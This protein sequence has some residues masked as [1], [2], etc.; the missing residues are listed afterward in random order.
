M[1]EYAFFW[2]NTY[3]SMHN[4]I[5]IT[6]LDTRHEEAVGGDFDKSM[7]APSLKC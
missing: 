7:Y 2:L 3:V 1:D 4:I 6:I 5:W